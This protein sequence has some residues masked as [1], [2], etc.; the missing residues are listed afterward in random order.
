MKS[1]SAMA[2]TAAATGA[3]ARPQS[4]RTTAQPTMPMM[5]SAITAAIGSCRWNGAGRFASPAWVSMIANRMR[6]LMAPR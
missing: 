1:A 4:V 2:S 3:A 6:T 5:A